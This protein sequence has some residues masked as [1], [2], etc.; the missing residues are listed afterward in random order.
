MCGPTPDQRRDGNWSPA[1]KT[2]RRWGTSVP[3]PTEKAALDAS[4]F[5][6]RV[7]N[8]AHPIRFH[9]WQPW[10]GAHGV[11]HIPPTDDEAAATVSI[12]PPT[13]PDTWRLQARRRSGTVIRTSL[14]YPSYETAHAAVDYLATLAAMTG[15]P[16]R[17]G[18]VKDTTQPDD[19]VCD[20]RTLR[21]ACLHFGLDDP[22]DR[23][24]GRGLSLGF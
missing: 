5:A 3:Y 6:L 21:A 12:L 18:R 10:R 11:G 9:G 22:D 15:D 13:P 20:C 19:R 7:V 16:Q 23:G 8:G 14:P 2:G 4:D 1:T 17:T 24:H